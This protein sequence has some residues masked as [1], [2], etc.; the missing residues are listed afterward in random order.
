MRIAYLLAFCSLV[1]FTSSAQVDSNMPEEGALPV[2][3]LPK[4][5]VAAA[6]TR[7]SGLLLTGAAFAWLRDDGVYLLEGR[8]RG[9]PVLIQVTGSARVLHFT[10][11]EETTNRD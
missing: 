9:R 6:N 1:P 8:C 5:V 3:R 10:Y 7:C 2:S 11:A 4:A